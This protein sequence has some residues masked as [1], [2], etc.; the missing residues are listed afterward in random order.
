MK[1]L[2]IGNYFLGKQHPPNVWQ[3]LSDQLTKADYSVLISS[4]K[5]NKVLR[6]L[7]MLITIIRRK[8]Q[9]DIAKIDVF[10]GQ[11]FIWSF[12][13]G[14][15]L[16]YLNKPFILTLHGGNLPDYA[17]KHPKRVRWL[18]NSAKKVVVPSQYLFIAMQMYRTD[19]L[20]IPNAI[21][22]KK[23]DF[24]NRTNIKPHL[25]WL[26]AFHKIYN[27]ELAIRA[28][29]LLVDILPEVFLTMIGPDKGDGSLQDTKRL[30]ENLGVRK[31]IQFTGSIQKSDVPTYLNKGDIFINTTNYDNTPISVMEA[32]AC[33]MCVI[34]T[35]VGGVPYLVND[36]TNGLLVPPDNPERFA[37]AIY[38][39]LTD[40]DLAYKLSS[41]ARKKA[42]Q[43]D[44]SIILPQWQKLLDSI[45]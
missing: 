26:R 4:H 14:M 36:E 7:D 16:R 28:L 17:A 24:K 29:A 42:E 43:L 37:Q 25:I 33:G 41:N 1:T 38:R 18:L 31:Y 6:L 8:K 34:S 9:F 19:L 30:A 44:W 21:E 23:Y 40:A 2:L 12:M 27:P 39:V 20:L 3:D 45:K 32:M 35:N 5:T 13:S 10:S 15:L 22:I 11:A